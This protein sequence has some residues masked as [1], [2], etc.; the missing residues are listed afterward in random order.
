M[1]SDGKSEK[2]RRSFGFLVLIFIGG[3]LAGAVITYSLVSFESVS[4]RRIGE[5]MSKENAKRIAKVKAGE[6]NNLPPENVKVDDIWLIEP[7]SLL[8]SEDCLETKTDVS[9]RR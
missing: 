9:L 8:Q 7:P 1:E 3:L 5:M 4:T 2:P 6:H